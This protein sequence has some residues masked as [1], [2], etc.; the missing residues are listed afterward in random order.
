MKD[1][2]FDDSPVM[3]HYYNALSILFPAWEEVFAHVAEH[4]KK[5]ISDPELLVR[6]DKFIA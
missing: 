2:W 5:D 4:R 6:M 3:T 1:Y